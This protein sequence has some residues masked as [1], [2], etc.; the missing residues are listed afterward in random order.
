L[1]Q[2]KKPK[3]HATTTRMIAPATIGKVLS[4]WVWVAMRFVSSAPGIS[5]AG[6]R[7]DAVL[8]SCMVYNTALSSWEIVELSLESIEEGSGTAVDSGGI[9]VSCAATNEKKAPL[10]RTTANKDVTIRFVFIILF[11]SLGSLV[12]SR[13]G[14]II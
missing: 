14:L 7:W 3:A 9:S 11:L 12:N 4:E 10:R 13:G 2:P 1:R 5:G 6:S 8:L